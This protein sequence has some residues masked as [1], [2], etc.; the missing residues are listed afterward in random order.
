[1]ADI[2]PLIVVLGIE[3]G[4]HQV[5]QRAIGAALAL[6]LQAD[7]VIALGLGDALGLLQLGQAL[8]LAPEELLAA[9]LNLVVLGELKQ[10]RVTLLEADPLAR[11]LEEAKIA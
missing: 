6:D 9:A 7:L 5:D 8:A 4:A 3:G 1:M 10:L 11:A 2:T